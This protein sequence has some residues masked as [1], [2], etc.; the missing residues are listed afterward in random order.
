MDPYEFETRQGYTVRPCHEQ[1]PNR[2]HQKLGMVVHTSPLEE[3][4]RSGIQGQFL[5]HRKCKAS[6]GYQR[7]SQKQTHNPTCRSQTYT[8]TSQQNRYSTK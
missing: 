4:R 3:A 8:W 1:T 2:T 7:L 5:L 6:L